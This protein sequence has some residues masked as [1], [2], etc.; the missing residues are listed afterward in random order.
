VVKFFIAPGVCS[1]V[2]FV[3]EGAESLND[4]AAARDKLTELP[5]AEMS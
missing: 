3:A 2:T 5:I 1:L 4:P